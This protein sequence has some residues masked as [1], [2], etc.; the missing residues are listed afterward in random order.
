MSTQEVELFKIID[1]NDNPEK[2]VLTA[3]DVFTAFLEQL[4]AS[5]EQQPA[6]LQG[7]A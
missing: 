5:Q 6:C 4:E 3:I 1:E 2:A 7:S